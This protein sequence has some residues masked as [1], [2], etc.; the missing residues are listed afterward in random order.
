MNGGEYVTNEILQNSRFVLE[1]NTTVVCNISLSLPT[2]VQTIVVQVIFGNERFYSLP[3]FDPQ[4]G[5]KLLI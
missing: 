2:L 5:V 3:V 4:S 1:M